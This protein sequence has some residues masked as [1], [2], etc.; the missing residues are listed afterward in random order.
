VND[1]RSFRMLAI[2]DEF[3]RERLAID[4]ARQLTSDDV[5]NRLAERFVERG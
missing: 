1:G 5:P 4:V 2:I 3:T